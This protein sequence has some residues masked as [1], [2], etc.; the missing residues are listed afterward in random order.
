MVH[1][2]PTERKKDK[3][4]GYKT[5]L[6]L[7]MFAIYIVFYLIFMFMCV[8]DPKL[9]SMKIGDLNLAVAFGFFLIIIAIIQALIYN[10]LCSR[11]EKHDEGA[12]ESGGK[13]TK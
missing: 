9:V 6:G 7:I 11:R 13:A 3:S 1:G 10:F 2:P 4:E 12:G 8:L 5:K